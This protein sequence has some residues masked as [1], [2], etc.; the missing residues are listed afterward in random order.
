MFTKRQPESIQTSQD[1]V[2]LVED[3]DLDFSDADDE[4]EA[5]LNNLFPGEQAVSPSSY[6]HE[7]VSKSYEA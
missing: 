3:S 7:S 4:I 6:K 2:E 5:S 1:I